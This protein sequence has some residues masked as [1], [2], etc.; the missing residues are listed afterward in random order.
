MKS[1]I[2]VSIQFLLIGLIGLYSGVFGGV[3][4]NVV[5]SLGVL[6]G[7]WAIATMRLRVNIFPD[8]Q[9]DQQL[10]TSGPYKYLRHPMYTAVLLVTLAWVMN[11]VNVLSLTLWLLL[12]TNLILKLNYEERLLQAKFKSYKSYMQRTKRLIPFVY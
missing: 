2:F 7:L 8:V 3:F 1:F 5:M 6:L 10:F 9:D 11:W 12:L 4:Q